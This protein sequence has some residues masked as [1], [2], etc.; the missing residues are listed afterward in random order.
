LACLPIPAINLDPDHVSVQHP[1][2][3]QALICTPELI[4]E[5]KMSVDERQWWGQHAGDAYAEFQVMH[6]QNVLSNP[7]SEPDG[8]YSPFSTDVSQPS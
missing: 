5:I 4:F 3:K 2:R 6:T 8:T 1:C 7:R